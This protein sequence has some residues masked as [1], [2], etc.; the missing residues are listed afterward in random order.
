MSDFLRHLSAASGFL[1][2]GMLD[3]AANELEEIPP[4]LKRSPEVVAIRVEIYRAASK[5]EEMAMLSRQLVKMRPDDSAAWLALAFA[6]RRAESPDAELAVL[7]EEDKA[8]PSCAAVNWDSPAAK[9]R[10]GSTVM[11]LRLRADAIRKSLALSS[12]EHSKNRFVIAEES[13]CLPRQNDEKQT[14]L[15][16]E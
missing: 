15:S 2:L 12:F 6:V 8:L 3:D 10:V 9:L 4:V 14:L 16:I 13:R 7:R 11:T 5:W 1:A